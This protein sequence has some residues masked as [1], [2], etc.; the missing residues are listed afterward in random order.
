MILLY[1]LAFLMVSNISY[2]S[3]KDPDLFKRQPFVF[4]VLGIVLLIVIVAKPV[5][6]LFIIGILY[7]VSGPIWTLRRKKRDKKLETMD[8]VGDE[9]L[10]F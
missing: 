2:Y 3:F 7:L 4:L 10:K 9:D 1:L 8:P 5:V 6:M